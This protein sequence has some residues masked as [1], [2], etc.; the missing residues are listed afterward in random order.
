MRRQ[1]FD[2]DWLAGFFVSN[3][4]PKECLNSDPKSALPDSNEIDLEH[5]N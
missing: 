3:G 2:Q 4:I 1:K 5:L